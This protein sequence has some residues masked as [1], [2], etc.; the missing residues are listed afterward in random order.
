M[1]ILASKTIPMNIRFFIK[2]NV[3]DILTFAMISFFAR[4]TAWHTQIFVF[5]IMPYPS[6][7]A[8]TIDLKFNFL[9]FTKNYVTTVTTLESFQIWCIAKNGLSLYLFR[10]FFY[11]YLHL[12]KYQAYWQQWIHHSQ[13]HLFVTDMLLHRPSTLCRC[14]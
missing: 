9:N 14:I 5:G 10:S 7:S 1:R 3:S 13:C 6:K 12:L 8:V 11:L 4:I 2:N